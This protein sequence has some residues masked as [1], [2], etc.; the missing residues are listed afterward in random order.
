MIASFS[1]VVL[2]LE[3]LAE[4]AYL[5]GDLD[6]EHIETLISAVYEFE[7]DITPDFA[8]RA[9]TALDS[10][11]DVFSDK[12]LDFVQKFGTIKGGRRALKGYA[13]K[14][15]KSQPIHLYRNV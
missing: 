13:D 14:K 9:K 3:R 5:E 10:L 8:K 2:Q 12:M 15:L 1:D 11:S 4:R 6:L 7:Y